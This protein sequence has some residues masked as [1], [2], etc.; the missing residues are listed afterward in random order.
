MAGVGKQYTKVRNYQSVGWPTWVSKVKT[1]VGT[2]KGWVCGVAKKDSDWL[3]SSTGSLT[4][5][6]WM[7]RYVRLSNKTLI[8]Y[9]YK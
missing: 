6:V 9:G 8:S 1:E 7:G 4:K 2:T 5:D 3:G